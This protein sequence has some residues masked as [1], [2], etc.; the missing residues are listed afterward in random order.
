MT[1]SAMTD[2]AR[3][4]V[5]SYL[6]LSGWTREAEG[7]SGEL[8]TRGADEAVVPR[9]LEAESAPWNRLALALAVA[10]RQSVD[11]VLETLR[12]LMGLEMRTGLGRRDPRPRALPGRVEMEIHLDGLSVREHQTGAY[13]FGRFVMRAA[14]S[15]KELV[16]SARG[17]RHHPR[18]LLVVGGPAPGSV[19]VTFAEPDR[20][21]RTALF[22]DAPETAEGQALV[23]MAGVFSAAEDSVEMADADGLRSHL[24]PLGA[25]AR[26]SVA[27]VAESLMDGGWI[28]TGSIRR[29]REEV[30]VQLGPYGARI[31]R[32]TSREVF[33][34]ERVEAVAGTLDGWTWS[35]SEL[36]LISDDRGTI[37]VSVPMPLQERVAE[38]NA[39]RDTRVSTRLSIYRRVASGTNDSMRTTYS[40]SAIEPEAQKALL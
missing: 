38:L 21:D 4:V 11:D 37:R 9:R 32:D 20:S 29:G 26:R 5:E 25:P 15:I 3:A 39:A 34:E 18:D 12:S 35:T 22:A 7:S 40:L 14:D 30:P 23:F 27:R 2:S 36:T 24:A 33:E 10:D 19:A 8:W 17:L 16:K 31:L 28:L 6:R 13:H 1:N